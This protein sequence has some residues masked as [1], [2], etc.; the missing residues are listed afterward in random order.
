MLAKEKESTNSVEKTKGNVHKKGDLLNKK[1]FER[2]IKKYVAFKK[3]HV[4]H[5]RYS[6]TSSSSDYSKFTF[7]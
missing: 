1:T 3:E 5:F 4:Q 2:L 6:A 7:C